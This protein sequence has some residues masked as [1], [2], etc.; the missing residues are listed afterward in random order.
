[1]I[2]AAGDSEYIETITIIGPIDSNTELQLC[3]YCACFMY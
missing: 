2:V 1:M 3:I